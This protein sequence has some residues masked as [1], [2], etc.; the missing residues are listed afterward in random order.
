M[1]AIDLSLLAKPK[2]G[3]HYMRWRRFLTTGCAALGALA[4]G[5]LD[6]VVQVHLAIHVLM[7]MVIGFC[8]PFFI[9]LGVG[10]DA[11]VEDAARRAVH[12]VGL[13][14]ESPQAQRIGARMESLLLGRRFR[15]K[16]VLA[17]VFALLLTIAIWPLCTYAGQFWVRLV[18]FFLGALLWQLVCRPS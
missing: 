15:D 2:E 18:G 6:M 12:K 11:D 13:D 16:L 7:N 1:F 4:V 8:L 10:R 17:F 5:V 9:T 3:Q 14:L